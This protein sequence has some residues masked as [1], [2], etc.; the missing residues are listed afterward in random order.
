MLGHA[1]AWDYT[2]SF[3]QIATDE[4]IKALTPE[5]T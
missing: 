3:F 2:W 1:N 4:A 5:N